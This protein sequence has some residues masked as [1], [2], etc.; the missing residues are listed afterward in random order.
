MSH[1]ATGPRPHG[2][3]AALYLSGLLTLT[4]VAVF[5]MAGMF[6]SSRGSS[7][8]QTAWLLGFAVLVFNVAYMAVCGIA[9]ACIRT[10]PLPRLQLTTLPRI[11]ICFV[12]KNERGGLAEAMA[13]SFA[14]N[15]E[16]GVDLW[17]LSN[18]DDPE[19]LQREQDIL[20]RLRGRFG[21]VHYFRTR[22]NPL[23]RKHVCVREWLQENQQYRY[24][25]VCDADSTLPAGTV[26]HLAEIAE[27]P[28]HDRVAIFQSQIQIRDATTLFSQLLRS[29]QDI[30][31]RI[32]IRVNQHMLG[33]GV[34]FGS[35]ALIRCD[36][37]RQLE[38]P[39]RVLSHDIWDTVYLAR[40]GHP[41]LHCEEVVTHE[42][43]PSNYLE[44]SRRD[45]RWISGTLESGRL[46]F[47][48]GIPL[49]MRF[50]V[51][52][53]IYGYLSQPV[54]LLWIALG[55]LSTD[56]IGIDRLPLQRYAFLGAS[57]LHIEVGTM[58]LATMGIIVLH[59]MSA[60]RSPGDVLRL[61]GEVV[62]STLLCLNNV[63]Y[64]SLHV[65]RALFRSVPWVPMRKDAGA[66]LTLGEALRFMWPSTLL[67]AAGILL[68]LFA[69]RGW[70]LAAS[71]FLASFLLGIPIALL[72]SRSLPALGSVLVRPQ[73]DP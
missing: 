18:S 49:G 55:L 2:L 29:A 39:D 31:Q 37:F 69:A 14:V 72:S 22:Q 54:F 40:A 73:E 63:V 28:V 12:V 70:A 53:P 51:L 21:V 52:Y 35:G 43:F 71:P 48:P 46:A 6:Q 57:F 11:A 45:R 59:R 9:S 36:H 32:Y 50:Y 41:T 27:H 61:L 10:M 60:A 8:F 30:G 5:V 44:A 7:L 58:F 4:A 33:F 23:G 1:P 42:L 66:N 13:A 3:R 65:V 20:A 17:L 47:L 38:V 16:D 24:L 25:V 67:G 15:R 26:R 64:V 34:F 56:P 68:G 19:S 62:F